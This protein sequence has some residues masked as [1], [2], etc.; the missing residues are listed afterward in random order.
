MVMLILDT[1]VQQCAV[2]LMPLPDREGNGAFK[3]LLAGKVLPLNKGHAEILLDQ[4]AAVLDEAAVELANVKQIVVNIGPG[5]FTGIR[6]GV[7]TARALALVLDCPTIGVSSLEALAFEARA[8]LEPAVSLDTPSI[9]ALIPAGGERV[10]YQSFDQE[11]RAISAP[12]LSSRE[13]LLAILPTQSLLVGSLATEIATI[14][15]THA[16]YRAATSESITASLETYGTL[17]TGR[18]VTTPAQPL[19]LRG[20]DAKVQTGFALA[21]GFL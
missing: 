5:S 6:V 14:A 1:A 7:A 11:G 17:A 3:P 20:A 9:T 12:S 21:H 16:S 8:S 18:L 10:Y 4:L 13:N 15:A 19:Y 2:G